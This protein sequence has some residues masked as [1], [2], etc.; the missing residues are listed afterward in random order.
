MIP[1]LEPIWKQ[2]Q[3]TYSALREALEAVPDDRLA[4]RPGPKANTVSWIV[5]HINRGNL[6][7]AHF[8]ERGDR[9]HPP[10][11]EESPSRQRL[12]DL[13]ADSER[14]VRETFERMTAE[15]LNQTR[16]EDWNPLGPEVDGPLDAG[17]FALQMVRHSAYHLGQINVYL[18]IWE[19]EATS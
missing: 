4:W 2:F 19:G 10:E 5:Q 9:G 1:E 13:L 7:Y 11:W 17:W 15:W 6:V 18:L 16:A 8:M 12:V 3:E 14:R